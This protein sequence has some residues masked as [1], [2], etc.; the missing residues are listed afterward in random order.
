MHIKRL[1]QIG[2]TVPDVER[3]AAFY[4]NIVGLEISDRADG[5]IFLRSSAEHH[6]L[7]L[8][9]GTERKLHHVGLEVHDAAALDTVRQ[10]LAQHDLE[11][12][13]TE[14]DHPGIGESI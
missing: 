2:M 9:P 11:A 7:C 5:A 12:T 3:V 14:F 10:E 4:E 13:P 1:G 8:Y 6:C